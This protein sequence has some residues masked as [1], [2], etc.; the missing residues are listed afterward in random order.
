MKWIV[1]LAAETE[2]GDCC[3]QPVAYLERGEVITPASPRPE[4]RRGED[5]SRSDSDGD[6]HRTGPAAR[7]VPQ[8]LLVLRSPAAHQGILLIHI[9]IGLWPGADARPSARHLSVQGREP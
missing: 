6:V 3:E 5:Y 9:S 1:T 8:A 2:S 7:R 4:H